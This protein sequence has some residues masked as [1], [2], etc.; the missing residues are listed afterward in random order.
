M[1]NKY[2][3]DVYDF[4]KRHVKN[5]TNAEL[6]ELVNKK[7]GN[8]FTPTKLK[9]YK[10]N[11]K[12]SSNLTGHFPKGH[13]PFNKGKKM[14][15]EVYEKVKDTMFQKGH[16][17]HNHRPVGSERIN[18]KD[19]MVLIKVSEPNKW[20]Y[21]QRYIWEQHNGSVPKGMF[22]TFL[23]GNNRNFSIENLA[24]IT[25]NENARLNQRHLRSEFPE[26][27]QAHINLVKLGN[28]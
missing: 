7:F 11:H 1:K 26:I 9:A 13:T 15:T 21:K 5:K 8:I 12:L 2:G 14:P 19:N 20:V 4:I 27:T 10:N 16:I 23:D 25:K 18:N 24:C 28:R 6:L 22:I 3:E 17:P